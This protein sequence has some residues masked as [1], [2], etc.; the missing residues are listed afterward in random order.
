MVLMARN[1]GDS[2]KERVLD[3]RTKNK[4]YEILSGGGHYTVGEVATESGLP[5]SEAERCL[6]ALVSDGEARRT[7]HGYVAIER[8]IIES[9]KTE[10]NNGEAGDGEPH[11]A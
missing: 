8:V 9:H 3:E 5:V 1:S 11:A 10:G 4:V 6:R 7:T 2:K